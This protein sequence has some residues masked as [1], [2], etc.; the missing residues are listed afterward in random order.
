MSRLTARDVSR[1]QPTSNPGERQAAR[2]QQRQREAQEVDTLGRL[3]DRQAKLSPVSFQ[4]FVAVQV[5]REC[6]ARSL[7]RGKAGSE[8]GIFPVASSGGER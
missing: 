3:I 1:W 5:G 4:A 6:L 2:K 7:A 8:V